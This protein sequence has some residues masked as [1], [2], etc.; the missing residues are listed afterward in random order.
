VHR[1][2]WTLALLSPGFLLSAWLT[3]ARATSIIQQSASLVAVRLRNDGSPQPQ[4]ADCGD[5]PCVW[6][7][8]LDCDGRIDAM[9]GE[10]GPDV[11]LDIELAPEDPE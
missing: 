5:A 2:I 9:F 7:I 4:G 3:N 1:W 11:Y 8:K 10:L 6:D